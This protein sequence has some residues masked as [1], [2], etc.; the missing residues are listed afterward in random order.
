MAICIHSKKQTMK[1]L[2]LDISTKTG[3][4]MFESPTKHSTKTL[5]HKPEKCRIQRALRYSDDMDHLI[6]EFDP[7]VA[8]IEGYGYGNAHTLVTLVEI[9]TTIRSSLVRNSVP[10]IEV[11]PTTLKK[12]VCGSGNAAKELMIKEIYK[13]WGAE[14][15]TNDEADAFALGMMAYALLGMDVGIPKSH[16]VKSMEE[17]SI[18]I[19]AIKFKTS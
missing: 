18:A 12:F 4:G 15:P 9:G 17:Y 2:A 3:V 7:D 16:M 13:R 8:I 19:N 6:Q 1:V 10:M 5:V 14:L 11:P